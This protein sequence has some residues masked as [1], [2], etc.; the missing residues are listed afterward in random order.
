MEI[1]KFYTPNLEEFCMGLELNYNHLNQIIPH[2]IEEQDFFQADEGGLT[3]IAEIF[4]SEPLVK[5]LD[6]TDIEELGFKEIK[7]QVGITHRLHFTDNNIEIVLQP[8]FYK[9]KISVAIYEKKLSEKPN[10]IF[11][12]GLKNKTELKKLLNQLEV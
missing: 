10:C 9:D 2:I 5:Y 11:R 6:K 1:E 8:D 3:F 12:G 4:Y 7:Q